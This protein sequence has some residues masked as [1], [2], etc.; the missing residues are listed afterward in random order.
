MPSGPP[1]EQP[2]RMSKKCCYNHRVNTLLSVQS[3]THLSHSTL[4]QPFRIKCERYIFL[5]K[6]VRSSLLLIMFPHAYVYV[7]LFDHGKNINKNIFLFFCNCLSIPHSVLCSISHAPD[8]EAIGKLLNSL[9]L[10]ASFQDK[11]IWI[12]LHTL[13]K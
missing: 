13:F 5:K 7:T 3:P 10:F 12:F 4:S 1:V 11:Q 9:L 2:S 8:I 6:C